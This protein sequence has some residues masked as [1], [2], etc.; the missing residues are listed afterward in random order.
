MY[1]P[2]YFYSFIFTYPCYY[3]FCEPDPY[4]PIILSNKHLIMNKIKDQNFNNSAQSFADLTV[5]QTTSALH[6]HLLYHIIYYKVR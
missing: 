2:G 3:L 1:T 5:E 6:L 4:Y